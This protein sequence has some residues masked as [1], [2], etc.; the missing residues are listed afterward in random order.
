MA[1]HGE[2]FAESLQSGKWRLPY[3]AF[4]THAWD[5][6]RSLADHGV[7]AKNEQGG[8]RLMQGAQ[9]TPEGAVMQGGGYIEL[10]PWEFGGEE[11]DFVVEMLVMV[12]DNAHGYLMAL[13]DGDASGHFVSIHANVFRFLVGNGSSWA[14]VGHPITAPSQLPIGRWVHLVCS[15]SS[16]D[17]R[18]D[19][20]VDGVK[21]GNALTAPLCRPC[22]MIRSSHWLGR[23]HHDTPGSE[24]YQ[25][26]PTCTIASYRFFQGLGVAAK[27]ADK[28]RSLFAC[29]RVQ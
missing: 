6:R 8:A 14:Y 9:L 1:P 3:S 27:P 25:Q 4:C 28:A 23:S 24:E 10:P 29:A 2:F 5:F 20:F 21:Q 11:E 12:H 26:S 7:E 19:V 18:C 16:A 15:Y 13:K 22:R 17:G